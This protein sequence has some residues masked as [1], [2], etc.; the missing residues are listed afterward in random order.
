[1]AKPNAPTSPSKDIFDS[2]ATI[3][4]TIGPIF[5]PSRNSL[6]I[7]PSIPRLKFPLS[8]P[9]T[10]STLRSPP[11]YL[12]SLPSPLLKTS[13]TD[14]NIFIENSRLN[15]NTPKNFNRSILISTSFP[16][17]SISPTNSPGFSVAISV[18]LDLPSNLIIDGL[19]HTA[20]PLNL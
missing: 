15:Y 18:P 10:A 2:I 19:K 5:Y 13:L 16:L 14:F 6:T 4:K 20:L 1:M 12:T 3:S 11:S 8:S 17:P 9:T 7:T